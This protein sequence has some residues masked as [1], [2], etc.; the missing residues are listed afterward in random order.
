MTNVFPI[1]IWFQKT[2]PVVLHK[3]TEFLLFLEELQ[4]DV[5]EE[6]LKVSYFC[7]LFLLV[8]QYAQLH[9]IEVNAS[10]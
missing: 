7:A 1:L 8:M 4:K 2:V 5:S 10:C 6:V 9:Q 3:E